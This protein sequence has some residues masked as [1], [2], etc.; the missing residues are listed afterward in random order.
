MKI[1]DIIAKIGELISAV[2][3]ADT[4]ATPAPIII[5]NNPGAITPTLLAVS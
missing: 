1:G 5:N 2:E 4:V 3:T